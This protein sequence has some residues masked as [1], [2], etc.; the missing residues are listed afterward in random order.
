M[1]LILCTIDVF[2]GVLVFATPNMSR[3]ELLFAV[4]VPPDF[5]QSR[6]GQHADSYVP[7]SHRSGR[8]R[9]GVCAA[10]LSAR[11]SLV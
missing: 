1:R 9:G 4:P 2:I 8:G 5:R 11:D 10:S 7:D 6:A 3:R